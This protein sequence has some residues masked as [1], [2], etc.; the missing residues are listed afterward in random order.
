MSSVFAPLGSAAFLAIQTS[1]SGLSLRFA[2]TQITHELSDLLLVHTTII[3]SV[4]LWKVKQNP[5]LL[6]ARNATK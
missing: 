6:Q 1:S 2:A 5:S 3:L 4:G